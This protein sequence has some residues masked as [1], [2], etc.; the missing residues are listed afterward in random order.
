[1]SEPEIHPRRVTLTTFACGAAEELFQE[2]MKALLA[3]LDD[4]NTE[5]KAKREIT[6]RFRVATD[7]HRQMGAMTVECST[8]LPSVKAVAQ[9]VFIG[10]H[11]GRPT[12]VEPLSQEE[13]FPQPSS[14]PQAVAA[15]AEG[16][17]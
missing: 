13:L 17:S 12:M 7:E 11:R 14:Q 8:K 16:V 1:M 4:V 3:N 15:V 6:L 10:R 5:W 2:A 9:N